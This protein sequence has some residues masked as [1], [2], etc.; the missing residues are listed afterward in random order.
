MDNSAD[1]PGYKHY[2]LRSDASRPG[3]FVA[4]LDLVQ[5]AGCAVNGVVRP[6]DETDLSEL[7]RR[8]RNY[9]RVDVSDGIEAARGTVWAYV[10]SPAGRARLRGAR[11][12]GIAVV[13]RDY[14]ADVRAG[15]AALGAEQLAGFERSSELEG[16]PIMQLD[17]IDH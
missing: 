13:S 15:F 5:D 10:G 4:F 16:L 1:L 6:V 12:A 11:G 17:R 2:L 3:V 8:E 9:E 14:L 7:D